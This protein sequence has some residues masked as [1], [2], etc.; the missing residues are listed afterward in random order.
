VR[1]IA[2]ETSGPALIGALVGTAR[3]QIVTA[4]LLSAGIALG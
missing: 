4:A 1:T 3:L 2:G